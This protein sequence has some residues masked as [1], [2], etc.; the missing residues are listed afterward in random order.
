MDGKILIPILIT[1]GLFALIFGIYYFRNRERMAMIERGMNPHVKPQSA[2]YQNLKWGLLLLGAGLGL[3][4]AS[5]L[6]RTILT[7]DEDENVA[8]YF[9]LIF[10]FGGL[11]LFLSYRIEKK[12]VL[13]KE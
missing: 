13:D 2:P 9:G 12:E 11:G 1:L 4:L 8:I 5:V 3:F 6:T 7:G 10:M